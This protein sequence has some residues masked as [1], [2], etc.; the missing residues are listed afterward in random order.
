MILAV[1]STADRV[2][3]YPHSMRTALANQTGQERRRANS[4]V[5]VANQDHIYVWQ[6]A[7]D[8]LS[9]FAHDRLL[10]GPAVLVID[11][12]HLLRVALLRPADIAL[13]DR[14]GPSLVCD[15]QFLV[16]VVIT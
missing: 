10:N 6:Q 5:V 2:R 15:Q 13:F 1:I 14:A 9:D 4:F 8:G 7:L 12:Q 3:D 16:N 11:A